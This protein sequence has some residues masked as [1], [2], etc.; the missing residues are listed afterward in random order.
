MGFSK[1]P[2]HKKIILHNKS[3]VNEHPFIGQQQIEIPIVSTGH[4]YKKDSLPKKK[5]DKKERLLMS[6]S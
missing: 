5:M 2:L 6:S 1:H 3:T 4:V